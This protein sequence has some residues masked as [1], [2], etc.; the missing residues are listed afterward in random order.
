MSF[1]SG[2]GFTVEPSSEFGVIVEAVIESYA[3]VVPFEA[4]GSFGSL[5][6]V[7][8]LAPF[9]A[10]GSVIGVDVLLGV[11]ALVEAVDVVE[12]VVVV[13]VV[14]VVVDSSVSSSESSSVGSCESLVSTF[15]V[16]LEVHQ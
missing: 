9:E 10:V 5:V 7:V 14:G 4:D 8:S 15:T 12:V 13:V 2:S 11:V 6:T 16:T 1:G 3:A